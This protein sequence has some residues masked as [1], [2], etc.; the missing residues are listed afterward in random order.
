MATIGQK[1]ARLTLPER[2]A[3][4]RSAELRDL[5]VKIRNILQAQTTKVQRS[6]SGK[7]ARRRGHGRPTLDETQLAALGAAERSLSAEL[8]TLVRTK[9]HIVAFDRAVEELTRT[10]QIARDV[11]GE[12]W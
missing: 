1:L 9:V 7:R 4:E 6:N 11:F 8:A 12:E 3:L 10:E 5:L 2:E